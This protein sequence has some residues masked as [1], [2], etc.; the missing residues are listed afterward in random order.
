MKENDVPGEGSLLPEGME[1]SLQGREE[2]GEF[3]AWKGVLTVG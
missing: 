3:K 2:T 1:L